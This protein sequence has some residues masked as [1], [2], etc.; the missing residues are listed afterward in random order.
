M[1]GQHLDEVVPFGRATAAPDKVKTEARQLARRDRAIDRDFSD[2]RLVEPPR[3]LLFHDRSSAKR[4]I[5][6]QQ[7][8]RSDPTVHVFEILERDERAR[9]GF[10]RVLTHAAG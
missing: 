8:V 5:L 9:A 2:G 6:D 3:K 10:D 4:T 1:F 7:L